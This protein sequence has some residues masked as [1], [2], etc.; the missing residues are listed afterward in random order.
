LAGDIRKIFIGILKAQP[1]MMW[2]G[3]IWLMTE[4]GGGL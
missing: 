1:G 2:N 4:A 3:F